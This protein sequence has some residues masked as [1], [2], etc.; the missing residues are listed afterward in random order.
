MTP[1]TSTQAVEAMVARMSLYRCHGWPSERP[2]QEHT[3]VCVCI[4]EQS[5]A[6]LLR[7]LAAERDE[8]VEMVRDLRIETGQLWNDIASARRTA[9]EDAAKVAGPLPLADNSDYEK[10][11]HDLRC[12]IA[13]E[14]R[15]LIETTN[16]EK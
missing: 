4:N 5:A 7:A 14:I 2:C 1:D 13:S 9:L 8:F 10:Q 12:V 3:G 16:E 11:A 15:A 6:S